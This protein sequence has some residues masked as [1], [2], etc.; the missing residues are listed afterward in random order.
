MAATMAILLTVA[1]KLR[2]KANEATSARLSTGIE[3]TGS[4]IPIIP[5]AIEA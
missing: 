4:I 1:E 5:P 3:K 2:V